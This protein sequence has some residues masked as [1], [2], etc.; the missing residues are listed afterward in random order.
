MIREIKFISNDEAQNILKSNIGDVNLKKQLNNV[1]ET[2]EPIYRIKNKENE[3]EIISLSEAIKMSKKSLKISSENLLNE[4]TNLSHFKFFFY[5][6]LAICFS[7]VAIMLLL[8]KL[9]IS[10]LFAITFCILMGG[11]FLFMSHNEYL[12]SKHQHSL[13][14]K[15]DIYIK[16]T[17]KIFIDKNQNIL[18][19]YLL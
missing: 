6:F 14:E 1:L 11:G 17:G 3:L 19:F 18:N 10:T 4:K 5:F 15:T 16:E 9:D 8:N 13:K 7:S 12:F 2:G